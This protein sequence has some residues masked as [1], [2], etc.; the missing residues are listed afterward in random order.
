VISTGTTLNEM[1]KIL[2][3]NWAKSVIWVIIASG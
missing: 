1:A 3:E 2:K